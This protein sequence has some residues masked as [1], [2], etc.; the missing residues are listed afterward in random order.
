MDQFFSA[1]RIAFTDCPVFEAARK[2]MTRFLQTTYVIVCKDARF[3][4]AL[5]GLPELAVTII[6]LMMDSENQGAR[7]VV[8]SEQPAKCDRC[9][10]SKYHIPLAKTW[11]SRDGRSRKLTVHGLCEDCAQR[12]EDAD[13]A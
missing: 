4:D 8:C 11:A 1:A 5:E 7:S 2:L 10:D 13:N 3:I 9:R 6:K 12:E